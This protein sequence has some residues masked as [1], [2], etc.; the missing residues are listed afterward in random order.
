MESGNQTE[1]LKKERIVLVD[2]SGESHEVTGRRK[3]PFVSV[4][5]LATGVKS[6]FI[7]KGVGK[8]EGTVEIEQIMKRVK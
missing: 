8:K 2:N 5:S 4:K 7:A 1:S 6:V 3:W